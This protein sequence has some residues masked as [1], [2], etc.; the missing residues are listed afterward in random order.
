MIGSSFVCRALIICT[1]LNRFNSFIVPLRASLHKASTIS[2]RNEPSLS[3]VNGIYF[4]IEL[5][6]QSIKHLGESQ[7]FRG[8]L[9]VMVYHIKSTQTGFSE[10]LIRLSSPPI[11]LSGDCLCA[12]TVP[13]P[14][15]RL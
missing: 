3:F 10:A 12:A 1:G 9:T 8:N 2:E 13:T 4:L 5:Q 15:V 6:L 14:R 7:V 11:W